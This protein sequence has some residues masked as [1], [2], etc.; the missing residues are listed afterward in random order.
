MLPLDIQRLLPFLLCRAILLPA[1]AQLDAV[2][3]NNAQVPTA[4]SETV[5]ASAVNLFGNTMVCGQVFD[6]PTMGCPSAGIYFVFCDLSV[7]Q[8][9]RYRLKFSLCDLNGCVQPPITLSLYFI[10]IPV[11]RLGRSLPTGTL[12]SLATVAEWLLRRCPRHLTSCPPRTG[13]A[14][15]GQVS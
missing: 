5:P 3:P 15:P 14:I 9:G 7:K 4:A 13:V 6:A 11:I 1:D 10:L 12:R 2:A 8:T